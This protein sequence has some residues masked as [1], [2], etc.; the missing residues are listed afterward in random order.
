MHIRHYQNI[1]MSFRPTDL[2]SHRSIAEFWSFRFF[3]FIISVTRVYLLWKSLHLVRLVGENECSRWS[4][5]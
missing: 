5:K 2:E 4:H 3:Y 1:L